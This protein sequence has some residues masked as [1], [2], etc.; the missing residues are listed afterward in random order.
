MNNEP[1]KIEA[2]IQEYISRLNFLR[3][4]ATRIEGVI[5]YLQNQLQE[6]TKK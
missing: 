6:L 1:Q 3:S 2:E 5:L 4:E